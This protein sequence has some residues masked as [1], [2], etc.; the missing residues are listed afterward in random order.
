MKI[1][2]NLKW[3]NNYDWILFPTLILAFRKNEYSYN[4]GIFL[5]GVGLGLLF[6]KFKLEFRIYKKCNHE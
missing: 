1:G 3:G 5:N 2:M 4:L 6:L